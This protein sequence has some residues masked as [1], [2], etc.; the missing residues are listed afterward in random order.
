LTRKLDFLLQNRR[1]RRLFP[2]LRYR[3]TR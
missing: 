3:Q 2:Q 1:A